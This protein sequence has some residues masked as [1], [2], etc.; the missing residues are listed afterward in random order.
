MSPAEKAQ[1]EK[2]INVVK[3]SIIALKVVAVA[4]LVFSA[5]MIASLH[6]A[7]VFV[8]LV[9]AASVLVL[10]HDFGTILQRL[11]EVYENAAFEL[12]INGS[13]G[14]LNE[15]LIRDVWLLKINFAELRRK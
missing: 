13:A 7:G 5:L 6:P 11:L 10:C 1:R 12:S 9:F 8:G 3:A 4:G 14:K 15:H 2:E